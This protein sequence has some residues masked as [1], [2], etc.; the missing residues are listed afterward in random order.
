MLVFWAIQEEW[1]RVFQD[2]VL[3]EA[4][5]LLIL[6]LRYQLGLELEFQFELRPF[7]KLNSK[8]GQ[9]EKRFFK[10]VFY[11]DGFEC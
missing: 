1:E 5:C 11:I 3:L 10:K 8:K 2:L 7:Q 6:D 9:D 4:F